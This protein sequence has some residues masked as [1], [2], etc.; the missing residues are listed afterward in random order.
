MSMDPSAHEPNRTRRTTV[1]RRA[2]AVGVS[3]GSLLLPVVVIVVLSYPVAT[4]AAVAGLVV[5]LTWT[6]VADR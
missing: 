1:T 5:G 3:L 2:P 6:D 4:A